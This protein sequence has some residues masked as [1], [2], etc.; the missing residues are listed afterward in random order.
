M[1][2]SFNCVSLSLLRVCCLNT[3][4]VIRFAVLCLS[5]VLQ[6]FL[7]FTGG[8]TSQIPGGRWRRF[9]LTHR[10]CSSRRHRIEDVRSL[11]SSQETYGQRLERFVARI[12][13]S[14]KFE[15]HGVC[16]DTR[17]L[18]YLQKIMLI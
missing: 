14:V 17:D 5:H 6:E 16:D 12:F 1:A 18:V 10:W 9:D 8:W 7:V 3:H 13:C 2:W 15:P 11:K 4:F